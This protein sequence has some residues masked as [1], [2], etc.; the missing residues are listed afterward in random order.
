MNLY[1]SVK[2]QAITPNLT[3]VNK[4]PNPEPKLMK[5][6]ENIEIRESKNTQTTTFLGT[7]IVVFPY[8][9]TLFR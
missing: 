6:I 2:N 9:N 5:F 7:L 4:W 1:V 3:I 8:F